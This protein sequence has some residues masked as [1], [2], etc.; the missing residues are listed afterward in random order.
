MNSMKLKL[1]VAAVAVV[2]VAACTK[3]DANSITGTTDY[4]SVQV[5]SDP[6]SFN[7]AS[8]DSAAFDP[9]ATIEPQDVVIANGT[10]NMTYS[11]ADPDVAH[12]NDSFFVQ[13]D[14]VGTT[15]LTITYTD[16]NHNFAT[17]SVDVPVTVTAA[18]PPPPSF[19]P[20]PARG[21]ARN[22]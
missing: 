18:A 22:H 20:P 7:V 17:T 3:N 13:G 8:G 14:E 11:F 12:I 9:I 4:T 10:A 2:A 1:A 19:V 5:S 16:V 21:P 6:S 15:T